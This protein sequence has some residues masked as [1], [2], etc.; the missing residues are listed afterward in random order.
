MCGPEVK[1]TPGCLLL[2]LKNDITC[3]KVCCQLCL[4]RHIQNLYNRQTDPTKRP[5]ASWL[6]GLTS[7]PT[8]QTNEQTNERTT[9]LIINNYLTIKLFAPAFS[10]M[11]K[12]KVQLYVER[13]TLLI[14]PSPSQLS[15]AWFTP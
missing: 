6:A 14:S 3:L 9:L 12:L 13:A 11:L 7:Q 1:W 5:M 4:I 8:D 15:F 2:N 10:L